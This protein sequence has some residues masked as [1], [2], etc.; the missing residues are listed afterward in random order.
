MLFDNP[1]E[2]K[3]LDG[4]CVPIHSAKGAIAELTELSIEIDPSYLPRRHKLF[5]EIEGAVDEVYGRYL[6]QATGARDNASTRAAL[7][8]FEALAYFRRSGARLAWG[9][10][11][12]CQ[13]GYSLR[14]A[15]NRPLRLNRR[16]ERRCAISQKTSH[17]NAV[18]AGP[19]DTH[20]SRARGQTGRANR[21]DCFPSA[22]GACSASASATIRS[23]GLIPIDARPD[24]S[25]SPKPERHAERRRA[26]SAARARIGTA[27]GQTLPAPAL[28]PA[29]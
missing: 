8:M 21:D 26:G 24:E 15:A 9:V 3:A 18:W 20:P 14:D 1:S 4:D 29:S 2:S 17:S 19:G 16:S 11:D 13:L 27:L 7:R 25:D 6:Q 22:T 28:F 23:C 5:G 12:D 10:A